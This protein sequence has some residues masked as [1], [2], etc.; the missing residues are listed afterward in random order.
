MSDVAYVLVVCAYNWNNLGYVNTSLT[1]L[2]MVDNTFNPVE[3]IRFG[4]WNFKGLQFTTHY[5][6]FYNKWRPLPML[7]LFTSP[8]INNFEARPYDEPNPFPE[9]EWPSVDVKNI[10]ELLKSIHEFASANSTI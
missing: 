1:Q 7:E 8:N 4:E 6:Q 10:T 9:W 5:G 3:S 2:V